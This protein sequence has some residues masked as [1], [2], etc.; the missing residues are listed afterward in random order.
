MLR[1][2]VLVLL[3]LAAIGS[4]V[5]SL[6]GAGYDAANMARRLPALAALH[7]VGVPFGVF[8]MTGVPIGVVTGI[9]VLVGWTT[10]RRRAIR[11]PR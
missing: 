8:L 7:D 1:V 11:T 6:G 10:Q 3:A 2:M 5:E 4:F 9:A